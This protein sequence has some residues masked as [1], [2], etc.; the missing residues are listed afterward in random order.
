MLWFWMAWYDEPDHAFAGIAEKLKR[1]DQNIVNLDSEIRVFLQ[2]GQYPVLPKPN[3]QGW[4]EALAYHR[5]K[6]IP[7]RFSVLAGEIVHHL[8]SCLDHL[9]W[10]F[11]ADTARAKPGSIEFPIFEVEPSEKKE[12]AR[13]AGKI[14]G[15][16]NT[17]VLRLI[18]NMQPYKAGAN[19]ANHPL[20]IVHNMDR[21]DKHRELVIVDSGVSLTI[22]PHMVELQ[23][24]AEL[25]T[26]G[27]LPS[28][29]EIELAHAFH[30]YMTTPGISFREFGK[31]RP[32]AIIRGLVQLRQAV[33][34]AVSQFAAEI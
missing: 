4:E 30:D 29:Q 12:I 5:D 2:S 15:I 32:Y 34:N 23:R 25:Y 20:L 27:E 9:V 16:T 7:L 18:E 33:G 1:A 19:I 22:P 24:M 28:F 8:R 21:F 6:P 17:N 13:Y 14:K 26:Q 11:S 10:H 3:T 31:H